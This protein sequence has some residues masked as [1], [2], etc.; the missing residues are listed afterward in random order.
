MIGV[1]VTGKD[2]NNFDELETFFNTFSNKVKVYKLSNE[3]SK[4]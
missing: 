3:D 4:K 2:I 1:F